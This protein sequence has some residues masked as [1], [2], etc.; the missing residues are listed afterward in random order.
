MK[1]LLIP[2]LLIYIFLPL[3]AVHAG[4]ISINGFLQGNYSFNTSA[5]N[6]DG[7]GFKRMEERGQIRCDVRAERLRLFIKTDVSYGHMDNQGAAELREGYIDYTGGL[8]DVRAGRQVVTWGLGDLIFI[9]DVFP[10]DYG[11]FFSGR[12][13]EYLKKGVDGVKLGIY[14]EPYSFEFM[15]IP[16][17]Q[18]N[19]LPDP[20]RFWMF[21]P[22]P[23][24]TNRGRNEPS[25]GVEM[26]RPRRRGIRSWPRAHTGQ[27][28]GLTPP[29]IS[30][31]VFTGTP[32]CFPTA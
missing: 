28:P 8:W 10:K 1:R 16:Y 23:S 29:S 13:M 24:V 3:Q 18:P 31:R 32:R 17:F 12:P 4:D 11:A 7:E 25:S 5:P 22:M 2:A 27:S 21:D 19:A 20:K 26:S 9:N 6:P 15:A 30:I 14:P